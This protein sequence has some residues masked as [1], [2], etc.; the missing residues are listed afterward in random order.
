MNSVTVIIKEKRPKNI[1]MWIT[2]GVFVIMFQ[3][4]TSTGSREALK[5]MKISQQEP[6]TRY[7]S[8]FR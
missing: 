1:F 3:A 6:T 2:Y 7:D 4:V 8:I 5:F